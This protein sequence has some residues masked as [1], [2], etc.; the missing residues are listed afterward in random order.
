MSL[1]SF[2]VPGNGTACPDAQMGMSPPCMSPGRSFDLS[3]GNVPVLLAISLAAFVAWATWEVSSFMAS[4]DM[5]M[6]T[7][8]QKLDAVIAAI[9]KPLPLPSS[10][11]RKRRPT[12][13]L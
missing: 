2:D 8:E 11:E 4:N 5:R 7:L 1:P 6:S 9:K 12:Q 3:R 13:G 10:D